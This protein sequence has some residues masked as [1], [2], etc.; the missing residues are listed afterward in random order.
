VIP[1]EM[2][3][4]SLAELNIP[5]LLEVAKPPPENRQISEV[6]TSLGGELKASLDLLVTAPMS[7]DPVDVSAPPAEDGLGL[8]TFGE[9]GQESEAGAARPRSTD[10]A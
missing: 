2:L 10:E 5:V 1:T 7:Y 9:P 8:R 4:G 3:T 6:W